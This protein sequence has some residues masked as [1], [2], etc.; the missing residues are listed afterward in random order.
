LLADGTLAAS[1]NIRDSGTVPRQLYVLDYL[2][3]MLRRKGVQHELI[4]THVAYWP[5]ATLPQE[6]MSAMPLKADKPELA[7]MT[8]CRHGL[9]TYRGI[10][11]LSAIPPAS[12]L[13]I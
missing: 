6:F 4:N 10:R 11:L 3:P 13:R 8:H 12:R 2:V 7:R 9:V 1:C 5:I